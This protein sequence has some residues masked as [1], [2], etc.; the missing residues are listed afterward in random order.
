MLLERLNTKERLHNFNIHQWHDSLCPFC[1]GESKSV[2][3]LF[4]SCMRSWSIWSACLSWW[5][6]IQCR[7]KQCVCFFEAWLGLLFHGLEQKLW[8][9]LK[10]KMLCHNLVNLEAHI[11]CW[12]QDQAIGLLVDVLISF[13]QPKFQSQICKMLG[14]DLVLESLRNFLHVNFLMLLYV[15]DVSV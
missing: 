11:V 10:K 12:S 7:P 6:I 2:L 9:F 14:N 15:T 3:H 1:K 13:S 4:F 5:S 8:F